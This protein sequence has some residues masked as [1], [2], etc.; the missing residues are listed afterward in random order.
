M[1]NHSL[2]SLFSSLLFSFLFLLIKKGKEDKK[3][4]GKGKEM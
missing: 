3:T 1:H 2:L 4:E